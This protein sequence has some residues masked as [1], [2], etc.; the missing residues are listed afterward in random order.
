MPA[1]VFRPN[2]SQTRKTAEEETFGK[3]VSMKPPVFAATLSHLCVSFT[4]CHCTARSAAFIC[5][6]QIYVSAFSGL[7]A[8]FKCQNIEIEL[9]FPIKE[10]VL[11]LIKSRR[12]YYVKSGAVC[13]FECVSHAARSQPSSEADNQ[14][15][16]TSHTLR[17]S[18][19]MKHTFQCDP[20]D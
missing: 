19:A 4:S 12:S 20:L 7:L 2:L 14:V 9:L 18:Y 16:T 5:Q 1:A 8:R 6:Q 17:F 11:L 15:R 3:T 13:S 10:R